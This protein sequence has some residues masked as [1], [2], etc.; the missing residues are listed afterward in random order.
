[1][2]PR[3]AVRRRRTTSNPHHQAVSLSVP[4]QFVER[5]RM[6]KVTTRVQL[7]GVAASVLVLASL[8]GAVGS[9]SVHTERLAPSTGSLISNRLG[10]ATLPRFMVPKPATL[11][12][13]PA[14]TAPP[15]PAP[16]SVA[17]AP[18]LASHEIFG[19]APYWMLSQSSGID[20][21][22]L[23]TVA[24]F[25]V[26]VNSDGTL[27]ETGAGWNGFQSQAFA[28]LVTRA[29]AAGDRVVLTVN[30]FD[31][32]TLNQLTSDPSSPGTLASAL[33]EAIESKDLDGVNIDFEGAGSADQS[34]LTNLIT[35]V[36]ANLHA[37]NPH[38]Q[39]SMDTYASSAGDPN[40]FYNVAALAPAVDAFFV[41]AYQLNLDAPPQASSPLTSSM[42]SDL[43][44]ARQYAAVVPTSKVILGVPYYGEDWATT[45]GTLAAQASGGEPTTPTYAQVV[46]SGHPVY[47]D[48][49]TDTA[50]TSYQVGN[51]WHEV[52]F[53]N[54]TSLYMVAQLAD[55]FRFGGLGIWTL[56]MDG[57]DSAMLSALSGN[58]PPMKDPPA[59]PPA[60]TASATSAPTV[61]SSA[62]VPTPPTPPSSPS[63][64]TGTAAPV[65]TPP[66]PTATTSGTT[67]ATPPPAGTTTT[68]GPQ[69]FTYGGLWQQQQIVLQPGVAVNAAT[70]K[71]T[72]SHQVGTLTGFS[73]TD[74]R[75]ACL[76]SEAQLTVWKLPPSASTS[77]TTSPSTTDPPSSVQYT[78]VTSEPTDCV[79]GS[80]TFT[81]TEEAPL[82]DGGRTS[83]STSAPAVS[84][85]APA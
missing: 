3:S 79:A 1:M 59:G 45:D 24:Y 28:S 85:N 57:N 35:Q 76:E 16:A 50:W 81:T 46:A 40:G 52:F 22:G 12:P 27:D 75:F 21:T 66:T 25:S 83:T 47:W 23:T 2:N 63:P 13:L 41:M 8:V 48:S 60:T 68:D 54:P 51:Q 15:T 4:K 73:T 56:G 69:V 53:E 29:H 84:V 74:P 80:F 64:P 42:F 58:A 31:Q 67:G 43:T 18:P 30:Q 72:A 34:G 44:T 61:P 70:L 10:H 7:I 5:I 17:D 6:L 33:V 62:P 78:V 26:G 65:T 14:A 71:G 11:A 19:F 49:V 39:V 77:T 20:V 55:V 38:W 36:S 37:T 82:A 9:D 32:G